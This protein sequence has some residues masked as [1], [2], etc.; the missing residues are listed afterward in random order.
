[1]REEQR[2]HYELRRKRKRAKFRQGRV[3]V[4]EEE[5]GSAEEI[6]KRERVK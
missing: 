2:G 5:R 4:M 1:M 6:W 3:I